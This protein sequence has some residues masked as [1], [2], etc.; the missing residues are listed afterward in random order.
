MKIQEII[1]TVGIVGTHEVN[2]DLFM[3]LR[4]D[5]AH[6]QTI[7]QKDSLSLVFHI[8]TVK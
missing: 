7:L 5:F 1:Q 8:V 3:K 6:I 2:T 4:I